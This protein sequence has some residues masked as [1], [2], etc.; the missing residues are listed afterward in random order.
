MKT[1][2][3]GQLLLARHLLTTGIT[4]RRRKAKT[5]PIFFHLGET[6]VVLTFVFFLFM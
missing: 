5:P 4:A 1:P 6:A 3:I 2:S